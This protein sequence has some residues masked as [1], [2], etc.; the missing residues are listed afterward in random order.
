MRRG[1]WMTALLLGLSWAAAHALEFRSIKESGVLLYDAPALSAKKLFVVSRHYPVE[2]LSQY[3]NWA[4]V[5][6]ATGSIAWVPLNMLS[7]ERWL[8]VTADEAKVCDGPNGAVKYRV[9]RDGAL[10]L[11]EAPKNGW[12][13]VRH[14]DGGEG[15]ARIG[16]LWG[17]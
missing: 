4:R 6:D 15:Y 8:L 10:A 9:A 11:L 5:R 1:A 3:K 14:R 16:D 12:V 2:A 7:R 13:K 17:L